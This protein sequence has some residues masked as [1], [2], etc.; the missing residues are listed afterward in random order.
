MCPIDWIKLVAACR[1]VATSTGRAVATKEI[2]AQSA[3]NT[4]FFILFVVKLSS[5]LGENMNAVFC[6]ISFGFGEKSD[7]NLKCKNTQ[8]YNVMHNCVN[9]DAIFCKRM[10]FARLNQ[11][12]DALAVFK[13]KK[14]GQAPTFFQP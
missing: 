9:I 14:G 5:I 7:S 8:I 2:N 3:N 1:A 10:C 4:V 13:T 11:L 12:W 6:P